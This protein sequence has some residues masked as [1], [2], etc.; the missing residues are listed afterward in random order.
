VIEK[1]D[2]APLHWSGEITLSKAPLQILYIIDLCAS[3]LLSDRLPHVFINRTQGSEWGATRGVYADI[4]SFKIIN[5]NL[6]C[7]DSQIR[8]QIRMEYDGV[9]GKGSAKIRD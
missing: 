9:C 3:P 8:M 5:G 1:K 6:V 7:T 2:T 4:D